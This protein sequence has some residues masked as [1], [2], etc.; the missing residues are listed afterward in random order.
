M[1]MDRENI[2]V[3]VSNSFRP[4]ACFSSKIAQAWVKWAYGLKESPFIQKIWSPA[5]LV[6]FYKPVPFAKPVQSPLNIFKMSLGC[7][8]FFNKF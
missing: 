1:M 6:T 5:L 2:W 4:W 3:L 7:F 8:R